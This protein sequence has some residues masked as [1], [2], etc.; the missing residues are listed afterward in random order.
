MTTGAAIVRTTPTLLPKK[1][2]IDKSERAMNTNYIYNT[3]QGILSTRRIGV[4]GMVTR[5][6]LLTSILEDLDMAIDQLV[7]DGKVVLRES[8]NDVLYHVIDEK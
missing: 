7:E 3:L 8:V 2:I 1:S 4:P 6:E 5:R